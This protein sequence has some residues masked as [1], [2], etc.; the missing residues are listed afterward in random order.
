MTEFPIH[1]ERSP[2]KRLRG[3]QAG[4]SKFL[5]FWLANWRGGRRT[6]HLDRH[7]PDSI[8]AS[9]GGDA[10]AGVE[11]LREGEVGFFSLTPPSAYLSVAS[12]ALRMKLGVYSELA[13][14][15]G[16]WHARLLP[17]VWASG[18]LH[19]LFLISTLCSFP[20]LL[21]DLRLSILGLSPNV[22]SLVKT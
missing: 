22:T 10:Q 19:V 15:L 12:I 3:V 5:E 4:Q 1:R 16:N 17:S 6:G 9:G 21:S 8:H 11:L 20:S 13:V 18:P 2:W 7:L 14:V